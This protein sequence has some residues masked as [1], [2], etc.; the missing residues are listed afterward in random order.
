MNEMN[1]HLKENNKEQWEQL[2]FSLE[3]RDKPT[4]ILIGFDSYSIQKTIYEK[5]KNQFA[6]YK[7]FDLDLSAESVASLHY[8]LKKKLPEKILNSKLTEYIVNVFGL[9]NS[10]F[11]IKNNRIEATSLISELNFE[12]EILFQRYPFII[13]VWTDSYTINVLQKEAKDLWDWI[14]Y[15]FEFQTDEDIENAKYFPKD[16]DY[17]ANIFISYAIED[18][19]TA[20]R[21]HGDLQKA[22]FNPWLDRLNLLPGQQWKSEISKAIKKSFFFIALLSSNSLGK[23]GYV[24]KEPKSALDVLEE[25]PSDK[26]FLIP[27]YIEPCEPFDERLRDLQGV[28]LYQ[29]Y[30]KGLKQILYILNYH[31]KDK[32]NNKLDFYPINNEQQYETI[33][34]I[35]R[36]NEKYDSI[37]LDDTL[38]ERVIKEKINIQKLLGQE[39][40]KL[41][42]YKKAE[43]SFRIA[44][45]LIQHADGLEYEKNELSFLLNQVFYQP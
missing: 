30:D 17:K 3:E 12:R 29:S 27:V 11:T 15:H 38:R 44:L 33:N 37:K 5:L 23:R 28:N 36:L 25:F 41:K 42:K 2:V 16:K 40:M 39:Y 21:L 20:I 9:E 10:L 19:E 22:G 1:I 13:I 26:I 31:K 18:Y 34:R 6:Q 24:H 8:A 35:K 14:L 7:F 43:Q 45:A 32:S 4:L